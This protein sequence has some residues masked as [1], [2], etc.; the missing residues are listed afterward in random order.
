[1]SLG[2]KSSVHSITMISAGTI[3]P[4]EKSFEA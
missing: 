1:V 3:Q 4:L 2:Q